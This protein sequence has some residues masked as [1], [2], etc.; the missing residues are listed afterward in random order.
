MRNVRDFHI[1]P[2]TLLV[3]F[4]GKVKKTSWVGGTVMVVLY[5]R[6]GNQF[7]CP[8]LLAV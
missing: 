2:E 4:A 5:E 7:R 1:Q 3:D 8:N 6:L